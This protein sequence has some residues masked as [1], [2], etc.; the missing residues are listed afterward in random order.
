MKDDRKYGA[1]HVPEETASLVDLAFPRPEAEIIPIRSPEPNR[2]AE[3]GPEVAPLALQV[4]L[5]VREAERT[6]RLLEMVNNH[7]PDSDEVDM[8]D[9]NPVSDAKSGSAPVIESAHVRAFPKE[10]RTRQQSAMALL[11]VAQDEA[12]RAFRESE[13]IVQRLGAELE[14]ERAVL[15]DAKEKLERQKEQSQTDLEAVS[16]DAKAE[17]ERQNELAKTNLEAASVAAKRLLQEKVDE[18]VKETT[19]RV[20][21]ITTTLVAAVAGVIYWVA[22]SGI[23]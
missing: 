16:R 15:R 3:P 20:A 2:D 10:K 14:A 5:A 23:F 1:Q 13:A 12:E 19:W 11:D 18:A 8:S 7:Q 4:V 17:L 22:S 21:F 6:Q 9:N